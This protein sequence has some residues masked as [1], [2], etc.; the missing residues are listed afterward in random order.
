MPPRMTTATRQAR[1]AERVG[2]GAGAGW[3]ADM[4]ASLGS[5]TP[6]VSRA[7]FG[8]IRAI[9]HD[10]LREPT[11]PAGVACTA[12]AVTAPRE[13]FVMAS[14]TDIR[15]ARPTFASIV[16]GVDGS[17]PSREAA[18]Q[19][20]LL[21]DDGAALTYAAISWEQGTGATAVATLSHR[22]AHECLQQAS[23]DARELGVKP[24]LVD[25]HSPTTP[26]D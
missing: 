26:G 21:T 6:I 22:H 14:Q 23:R 7:S 13:P 11:D 25:D 15:H 18:R 17:R 5:T 2:A 8:A 19:A 12:A 3:V 9:T 24:A 1:H 20:A 4:E 10:D 16:C